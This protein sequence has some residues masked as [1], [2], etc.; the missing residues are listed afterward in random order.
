MGPEHYLLAP[1]WKHMPILNLNLLGTPSAL[2]SLTS[3]QS[4]IQL[5]ISPAIPIAYTFSSIFCVALN[6]K[7]F[8]NLNNLHPLVRSAV[9]SSKKPS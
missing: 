6:Q 5:Y 9:I 3:P 8:E 1:H 2:C 7:P 4:S